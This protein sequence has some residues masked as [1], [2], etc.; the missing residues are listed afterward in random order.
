VE[1]PTPRPSRDRPKLKAQR[2]FDDPVLVARRR[3]LRRFLARL[4]VLVS[5]ST[6]VTV[7]VA[8]GADERALRREYDAAIEAD[9][10]RL[11][12]AQSAFFETNDRYAR[13]EELGARYISSQGVR[14][15]ILAADALGWSAT[16]WHLLTSRTCS[17]TSGTGAAALPGHLPD[18]PA[19]R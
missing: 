19:C 17:I 18:V 12:E 6:A 15:R 14:V 3:Q 4:I 7:W 1:T 16:G 9:L 8:I 2:E 13:L 10:L 11:G 5:L